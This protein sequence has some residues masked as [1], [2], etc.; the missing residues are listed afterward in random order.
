MNKIVQENDFL[1]F[2]F[3]E[4]WVKTSEKLEYSRYNHAS[5][6]VPGEMFPQCN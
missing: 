1:N 6:T 5:V 3:R 4:E 2:I